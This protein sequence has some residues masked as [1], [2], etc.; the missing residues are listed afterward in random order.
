MVQ[1]TAETLCIRS[2]A[3]SCERRAPGGPAVQ[4]AK[5]FV[6]EVT[7]MRR[8]AKID[9]VRSRRPRRRL[10]GRGTSPL[11][12]TATTTLS[13]SASRVVPPSMLA[14]AAKPTSFQVRVLRP[15]NRTGPSS[16]PAALV[17]KKLHF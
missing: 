8:R 15:R 10:H 14:L 2:Q 3:L 4:I 12:I 13:T 7:P 9:L 11:A 17:S 6:A 5:A 1:P 16:C